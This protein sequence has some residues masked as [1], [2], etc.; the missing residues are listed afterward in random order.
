MSVERLFDC[1]DDLDPGGVRGLY[2][3]GSSVAGGLRPDS[4]IDLLLLTERCLTLDER[5]GLLESCCGSR[6]VGRR[7][8]RG[9]RWI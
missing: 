7:S 1:I 2:L 3:F 8:S 9:A 4:D 5:A 6:A